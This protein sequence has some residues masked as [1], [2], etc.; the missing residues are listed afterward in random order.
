M[1]SILIFS[2]K[3]TNGLRVAVGLP[4]YNEE[5]NI[6]SIIIKL[7]RI[8]DTIIVCDDGSS[9]LTSKIA[10][11]LGAIT[12]TH[13]KNVGYGA[14]ITSLFAKAREI[15]IDILVT[16]D[17]DGQHRVEDIESVLEPI[18]KGEADIVIGSRFI[19][20][21]SQ[22]PKYRKIGIKAI[23]GLTNAITGSQIKDSQ[24]GF[25]AYTSNALRKIHTI[26]NGMGISTEILIK[27]SKNDLKI[28]EIP[29]EVTYAEDGST[30]NPVVHGAS[31]LMSTFKFMS[32]QK[33]LVFYG[34]PGI[35][36]L[37]VGLIFIGWTVQIYIASGSV[38]TN[39]S[40]IGIGCIIVGIQLLITIT[41]IN[42]LIILIKEQR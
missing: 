10:S 1:Q 2:Y 36:F 13:P 38:I 5:K 11:D 39:I 8:T 16:F 41:I 30:H 28:T 35:C 4:A 29:I 3:I 27:A 21:E 7:K 34:I 23:T 19:G 31:V 18:L 42:A 37:V 9:D 15:D 26:E 20:M 14:A 40:L 32:L 24:S 25:R 12:I 22:I 17:A 33:P 6:A